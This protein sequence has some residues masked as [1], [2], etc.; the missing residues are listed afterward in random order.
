MSRMGEWTVTLDKDFSCNKP[1]MI[2]GLPGI[3][4]VGKIVVDYLID[5]FGAHKVG[6]IFGY[7]L[8]NSVFV[9]SQNTVVLPAIDIYFATINK[10][11]FLFI[12][13][14][15]QPNG[16]RPSYTLTDEILKIAKNCD[17]KEIIATGGVGL[18]QAPQDAKVYILGNDACDKTSFP[19]VNTEVYGIVGT[20]IGVSGL[21]IG[22]EQTIPA[23]VLLVE[24][25]GHP[26]YIGIKESKALLAVIDKKYG[27]DVDY[28][29]L[30]E[31]IANIDTQD[32]EEPHPPKFSKL[33]KRS[34]INYI[35]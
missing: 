5:Q 28:T 17:C 23:S 26:M 6:S 20:I 16:E 9:T 1:I 3:G 7:D 18:P 30:D 10:Q 21:L 8:P 13:G 27:L 33:R 22:L 25:F 31:E 12:T 19:G 2:E 14:D 4:N 15:A 34:D 11:D 24:T 32:E 35:G 29:E